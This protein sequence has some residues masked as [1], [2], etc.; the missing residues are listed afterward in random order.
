LTA[1]GAP[2]E[3]LKISS[4][5]WHPGGSSEM[6]PEE[7]K[8]LEQIF[9]RMSEKGLRVV[10]AGAINL[11]PGENIPETLT[12]LEF[13]GF[14]GLEDIARAEVNEAVARVRSAG[15]RLV[16]ITGDHE[17]T[18]R[19]IAEETGILIGDDKVFTGE[20]I[21]KMTENEL[22]A[23]LG[24]VSVFARVTPEHK[25]RII[26]AYKIAGKTV[27][28][29]GDG[30]NDTLSLTSADVGVAMGK[31][32]TAVAK[33]AADI[34]LLDDNFGSIV[35]GVEEGRNIF[36]TIKRVILYLFSTSL[37][38]VLAIAGALVLSF[39]LPILPVQI[40]WLN[41]ITDGFLDVALATEPDRH[42][43]IS[44]HQNKKNSG[45]IDALM[46][47]RMI[48]M[49]LPMAVG[50]LILFSLYADH[51][52]RKAWTVSLTVL[53]VFQWLNAW[54]CRSATDSIFKN[55]L[56][57]KYLIAATA[58]VIGL[59]MFA[60][61]NPFFQRILRTVPLDLSEWN[62]I[63][64]VALSVVA[65]EEIRKLISKKPKTP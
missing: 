2:E 55:L 41:L 64:A 45:F 10:A 11:F 53:A 8:Q 20:D 35:A 27:A 47:K 29:T 16:M 12:E 25:L 5:F 21:E 63:V 38:E 19:T 51:D 30:V 42:K 54:N 43:N 9:H 15:I 13:V 65:V 39:P 22:A 61:Y 52:I 44:N 33:E 4:R 17:K 31:I 56:S 34:I 7:R 23:H 1:I 36:R 32:G 18:A 3:I 62:L 40:L 60:I 59:Q 37:G 49:A 24:K 58:A 26:D 6:C 46:L 48:L 50:T 57:N 14:L 28:M